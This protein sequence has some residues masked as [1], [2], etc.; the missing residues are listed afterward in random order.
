MNWKRLAPLTGAVFAVLLF[1]SFL[2]SGDTPDP[3][4]SVQE[5]VSFYT[6]NDSSQIASA[7]LGGVAVI[8]FVFF[9]GILRAE[10]RGD[11]PAPGVLSATAFGGGIML[12]LGGLSFAGF[13]FTLADEV[14]HLDPAASQALNALSGDFFLP[15]V[16]GAIVFFVAA[17]IVFVRGAA[18]PTWLGWVA[19]V[20]GV[21][22]VTPLFFVAGPAALLWVLIVS[23]ML[24]QRA[25]PAAPAAPPPPATAPPT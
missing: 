5:V 9:L 1:V 2:I 16:V 14:D 19:I 21:L 3:D 23:I 15:F 17:G 25:A 22:N 24:S 8:F 6:D 10:L 20:I 18:F 12:A 7:L 11:E 4:A 13:T